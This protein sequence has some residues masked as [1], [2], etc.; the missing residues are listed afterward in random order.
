MAPKF[1]EKSLQFPVPDRNCSTKAEENGRGPIQIFCLIVLFD[2]LVIQSRRGN[3][4][5]LPKMS[6]E[7][8]VPLD[9]DESHVVV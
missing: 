2:D 6:N 8:E 7:K 4:A 1:G 9:A 5:L 3:G